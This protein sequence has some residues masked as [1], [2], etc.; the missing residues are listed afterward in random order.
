[1]AKFNITVDLDWLDNEESIDDAIRDEVVNGAREYLLNKANMEIKKKLDAEIGEKLV[2]AQETIDKIIDQYIQAITT[3]N[4]SK[5]KIAEKKST[6]SDEVVMTPISEYI[7]KKFDEF[8]NTKRY[9]CDFSVA[10]Y[11]RDKIY[12]M[13]EKSIQEYLKK[14]LEKQVSDIVKNAQKNAELEIVKSLEDALKANLAEE[15]IKKMNIPQVLKNLE[16]TY[17]GRIEEK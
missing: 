5:L 10:C 14:I 15:T 16:A 9:N 17:A 8:C 1:M 11:D 7:G 6:W 12:S 3:D 13:A 2:Q 4:I